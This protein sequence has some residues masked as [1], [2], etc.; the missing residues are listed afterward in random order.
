MFLVQ[1]LGVE[2]PCGLFKGLPE[3]QLVGVCAV[4][5]AW[6]GMRR[7]IRQNPWGLFQTL[8]MT[9]KETEKTEKAGQERRASG[10]AG[11]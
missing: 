6:G 9:D 11:L 1:R 10:L 8:A 3:G 2:K 4:R 5:E 7:E